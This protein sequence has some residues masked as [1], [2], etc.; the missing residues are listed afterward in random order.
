MEETW[1]YRYTPKTKISLAECTANE[2]RPKGPKTQQWAGKVMASA[3]WDAHGILIID[4]LEKGKTINSAYY[5]ALLDILSAEIKKKRPHMQ[6]KKVLL[7]QDNAPSHRSMK[8][9]VKLNE[10]SFEMLP[11]PPYFPNLAPQQQLALCW[12]E[13]NV[14]GKEI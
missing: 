5:M 7:Y 9:I 6:K 2:S 10:L 14:P 13:K 1:I 3:F 12:P 4:Y 8:T 11:H